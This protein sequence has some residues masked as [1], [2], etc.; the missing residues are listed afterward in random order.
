MKVLPE[1]TAKHEAT[2]EDYYDEYNDTFVD[3]NQFI[4]K[5][6]TLAY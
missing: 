6:V 2:K 4:N 3:G 5:I 1:Y